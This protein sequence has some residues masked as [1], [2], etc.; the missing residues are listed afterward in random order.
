MPTPP[1]SD[2]Q[3]QQTV[4]AVNA[5]IKAGYKFPGSPS[6]IGAAAKILGLS[7]KTVGGRVRVAIRRGLKIVVEPEE[8]VVVQFA[9]L[10]KP[11]VVVRAYSTSQPASDATRLVII[12]DAH[13][14]PGM[15]VD[16]WKWFARHVA[17]VKP[18]RVVQIGDLGEFHSLSGHERPG[19]IQQK[20]KP[21]YQDDLIAVEEALSTYRA[22]LGASNIPHHITLGNHEDRIWRF[23]STVAEQ[24]GSLVP[25]FT[26]IL[27]RYDWRWTEYRR[28]LFIE[29]VAFTH[30]PMTLMERPFNGRTLNPIV[31]D[32]TTSLIFGHTHRH[33][34]L[35]APKL[36][37]AQRIEILNVGTAAP[38]GWFPDYAVSEQGGLSW[39]ICEA[40]VHAGHIVR[41]EFID[42]VT[43]ER[44]YA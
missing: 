3:A 34:F 41:H 36:G 6:A 9:P 24:E 31:N 21:K 5:A 42:M 33:A 13:Q 18:D 20:Q 16:R 25:Q 40:T 22:E 32:L 44:R 30:V 39:G 1:L 7:E 8:P 10:L 12:G 15:S 26:D 28:Y 38:H 2:A 27:A 4:D 14:A 35:N 17:A 23:E 11:R 19:S 37:P 43:L 29:N